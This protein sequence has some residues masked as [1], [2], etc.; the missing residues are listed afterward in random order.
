MA[1]YN[2]AFYLTNPAGIL[3]TGVGST[4][5]WSGPAATGGTATINDPE[6]GIQGTTLDDDSAGGE[7]ATATVTTP[8]GTSTGSPVDAEMV[9]TV[10][11]S[12]T[13][14]RFEVVQFEVESGAATGFYTLSE[15]P[16]VAGRTY[17][18]NAYNSNPNVAAGDIAFNSADYVD[19]VVDGTSGN[20]S[21]DLNYSDAQGESVDGTSYA[22]SDS[23]NAGAGNDTVIGG[24]GNDTI[25]GGTGNDLLYG[26]FG[27][28]TPGPITE[29]LDWTD[30]GGNGTNLA[31]G[32]TQDTGTVNVSVSFAN[33]GNNN[34]T[35]QV[36][37]ADAQYVAPG[38]A[39]DPNSS[40]FLYGNGD[41][42]TSTTTMTFA[43]S[44]GASVAEEVEN[45]RFRIND[46]DWGS[47]NHTDVVT[48]RAFDTAGNPVSVRLTPS[49]GDTVS[50]NTVTANAVADNPNSVGGSVL[51]EIAGPVD[52]IEIAYGNAQG[53][54]QGIWVTDVYFDAIPLTTGNDSL[55]GGDGNDT[56]FGQAGN[57]TL[58]GEAGADSLS[59]GTGND[60]LVGGDGNDTLEGGAGAD[61]LNAGEGMDF[62]SYGTSDAGVTVNLTTNTFSGGHAT[63]DVSQG[64]IDGIIGSAFND[65]LTGYDQQG[66]DWTNVIYG[67]AG[68]DTIDGLGGDDSL[69]GETGADSI[70]GGSGNDYIDGGADN[71]TIDGGTGN[72][73]IL[74]GDGNDSI[75]GGDGADSISAGSG[76]DVVSGGLGADFIDGG[77][78]DDTLSGGDDNDTILGGT[79][80]DSLS[81]DGGND[82]LSGG[83]GNDTLSG[84]I[85]N[86]TLDGGDGNDSLLGGDGT[87]LLTGGIGNDTL[88][89]GT[90]N[91]TLQGGD[92]A[93]SIQGGDGADFIDGGTGN[94]T[95]LGGTGNDTI[96]GNDGDDS[97]LAGDGNDGVLGG[98]GRDTI[99]G[100]AGTD[101]IYGGADDDIISG[102]AGADELYG[103]AGNDTIF[104]GQGDT[105]SGGDGDDVFNLVDLGEPG[106]APITILGGTTAQTLGD[107]LNLN[108]LADRT[109][110]VLNDQG[111]GEFSGSV[112]MLDG[113]VVNFSNIDNVICFT[114]GT[115]ILTAAGMVPVED[116][117]PGALIFTRDSGLQPLRWV[118]SKTV[119]ATGHLA[120]IRV[121]ASAL[122]GAERDLLVSPQHRFL[123]ADY[124]A[125]LLFGT[126]EV[127]VSA[128][129]LVDGHGVNR[130]EGGE[131][132]YIH[133]MLDRHE[134]IYAE[135][136]ATE[137]FHAGVQGIASL[138]DASREDLFAAFPALRSSPGSYGD[139]ARLC[140]KAHEARLLMAQM[141][142]PVQ[143]A[144]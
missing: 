90:G 54:T 82:S 121:S 125:E 51:V 68:N 58:L 55:L 20:D 142:A 44:A 94:D 114:P 5:V 9:W 73:T 30:Q 53:G 105:I 18:V 74:G 119:P 56:L 42:S 130:V 135:G 67:G 6:T 124:C 3:S 84:G 43:R 4:F 93:D 89:G 14:E 65:S 21:I 37:T 128:K 109:T 120:P 102:G 101:T 13:G 63:G 72:D 29:T 104:F 122:A 19:G 117:R 62:V 86:D 39:Y 15:V 107:T 115:R 123:F 111:G 34:P 113:S 81:G 23:I 138:S 64:G 26:D 57:D 40:L 91:D 25:S 95:I 75:L 110:L 139:A 16:L 96:G 49:G 97:I 35:Y 92:G 116:L 38:E 32:F 11:D 136:A 140:L 46:V 143:R 31:G 112:T 106:S 10:T 141:H 78:G 60:S 27:T 8:S 17:T 88:D 66:P 33:T 50:G 41:G 47:G 2:V 22:S 133:L 61:T 83:T 79:G 80:A 137:S 70:L 87:D 77:I 59:G 7:T 127:L 118:G 48:V 24:M 99:D 103:D 100:G 134:V 144:A 132:T 52:R 126:S 71:D 28:Y 76:N 131:V 85:G 69:Y 1:V 45:V 108:G 12:V 98:A 36:N 129:H